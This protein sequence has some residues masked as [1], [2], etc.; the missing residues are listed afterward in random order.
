MKAAIRRAFP[1]PAKWKERIL[2]ARAPR[3]LWT[4][5]R[6]RQL[7]EEYELRREHYAKL[8]EERGLA[9]DEQR[10][11]GDVRAR[12]AARGY[13]PKKRKMG[14]VHTFAFFPSF[15]W[16]HHLLPD[17]RELGPVTHFDYHEHGFDYMTLA[18]ADQRGRAERERML[19]LLLPALREAHK[20]RP[21]DWLFYYGGGQ[22]ISPVLQRKIAEEL[23]IPSANMSL[24]DKQGWAGR[25]TTDARTG[26]IDITK[27]FDVYMTSARVA[28]EWH[29]AEGGRAIYMPEGFSDAGFHPL[30]VEKDIPVS[31]IGVSYGF[32]PSIVDDLRKA[33]LPVQPFGAGW[34]T[35]ML[36][37]AEQLEVINRSRINLGMGGIEY[38]ERLTNVKGRDFEIP[39]TGGGMY[40]TT[41]NPD[42]ALHFDVGGEIVCYSTRDELI[43]LLRWYLARPEECGEIAARARARCLRE[44]R[45]LHRY[46]RLLQI[47]GVFE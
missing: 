45:W 14:E 39:G 34:G 43:E 11:I 40:L 15:S 32:R 16:H 20:K 8:L 19:S 24:D 47:L 41:F 44:H 18:A 36:S 38:S 29:L 3:E 12:L 23:G 46:E 17:L 35:K 13:T 21:V 10:T 42:L 6:R 2:E 31:F 33:R 28:C 37:S 25:Q 26:A 7:H 27:E 1:L 5:V 4:A 30:D 22:D 9:Y